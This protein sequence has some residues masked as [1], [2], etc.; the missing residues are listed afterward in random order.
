MSSTLTDIADSEDND[1]M[2]LHPEHCNKEFL[3]VTARR[4]GGV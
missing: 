3:V 2:T 1:D 4:G